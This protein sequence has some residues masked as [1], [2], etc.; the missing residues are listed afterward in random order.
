MTSPELVMSNGFYCLRTASP[1][2]EANPERS[3]R[4]KISISC[5]YLNMEWRKLWLKV[6]QCTLTMT[7]SN[8]N[9]QR[10]VSI[11]T[12]TIKPHMGQH[13]TCRHGGF[14]NEQKSTRRLHTLKSVVYELKTDTPCDALICNE[15]YN[16]NK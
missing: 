4:R 6:L 9:K 15:G 10:F 14:K 1:T 13:K 8:K 5:I 2:A 7:S 16:K 11:R 3:Y 12:N